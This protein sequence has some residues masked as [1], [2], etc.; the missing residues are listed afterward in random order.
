MGNQEG[1]VMGKY[2]F[3]KTIQELKK[4][5]DMLTTMV[6]RNSQKKKKR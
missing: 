2:G 3:N 5:L 6:R 1:K 4:D